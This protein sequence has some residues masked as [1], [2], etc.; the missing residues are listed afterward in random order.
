MQ[1]FQRNKDKKEMKV[2]QEDER[3]RDENGKHKDPLKPKHPISP[4][5]VYT[6][7]RR[8]V[9]REENKNV[10]EVAKKNKK[11]YMEA[12]EEYKRAKGA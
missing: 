6:N 2:G 10:V 7:E 1:K 5:L 12:M 4:F 11:T 8:A 9:F 3:E